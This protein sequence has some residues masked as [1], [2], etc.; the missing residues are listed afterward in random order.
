M[1]IEDESNL[2]G[3]AWSDDVITTWIGNY[4]HLLHVG[5]ICFPNVIV[6]L[7]FQ[8]GYSD[9]YSVGHTV[10]EGAEDFEIT[11]M[12]DGH[13]DHQLVWRLCYVQSLIEG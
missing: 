13:G 9:E 12:D 11:K 8:G 10:A 7:F 2:L 4:A 1:P 6:P 3:Q 5:E